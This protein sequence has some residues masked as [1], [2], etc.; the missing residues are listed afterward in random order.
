[1]S[2]LRSETMK[3]FTLSTKTDEHWDTINELLQLDFVHYHD[4]HKFDTSASKRYRQQIELINKMCKDVE[5]CTRFYEEMFVDLKKPENKEKFE[6]AVKHLAESYNA[7]QTNLLEIV[8]KKIEEMRVFFTVMSKEMKKEHVEYRDTLIRINVFK[9]I[10]KIFGL[11]IGD[12]EDT[13][14][15]ELSSSLRAN[16]PA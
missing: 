8:A 11:R 5:V 16:K 3:L 15:D 13:N 6:V 1:M 2:Q 10:A 12:S 7:N 9:Q 4:L 14:D